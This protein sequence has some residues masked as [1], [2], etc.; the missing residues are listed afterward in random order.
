MLA[1]LRS[2]AQWHRQPG[3]RLY[4]D[5]KVDG[6]DGREVRVLEAK[7]VLSFLLCGENEVRLSIFGAFDDDLVRWCCDGP[8][9]LEIT[10]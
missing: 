10:S 2:L 9:D 1:E 4:G 3:F 5:V 7:G 8:L 6:L